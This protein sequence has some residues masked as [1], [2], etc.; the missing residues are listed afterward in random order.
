MRWYNDENLAEKVPEIDLI[1]GGHDHEYE[2]KKSC[3]STSNNELNNF[4]K[5]SLISGFFSSFIVWS[6]LILT[7]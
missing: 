5:N 7:Y 6:I 1:I 2:I 4:S 3:L